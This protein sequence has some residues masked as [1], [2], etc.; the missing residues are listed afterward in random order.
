MVQCDLRVELFVQSSGFAW[1]R[2]IP[3][4]NTHDI[5]LGKAAGVESPLL[6]LRF[7]VKKAEAAELSGYAG[8]FHC[9]LER[10]V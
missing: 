4:D 3:R 6:S 7:R 10:R 8:K 5:S 2:L 9:L 1:V